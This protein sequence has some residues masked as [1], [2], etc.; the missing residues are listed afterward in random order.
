MNVPS[1]DDGKEDNKY[2]F[3]ATFHLT[4]KMTSVQGFEKM[5]INDNFSEL[6]STGLSHCTVMENNLWFWQIFVEPLW[7]FL[8]YEGWQ[9]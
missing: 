8:N 6:L 5:V 4:L 9:L 1:A 7:E 3:I 2:K